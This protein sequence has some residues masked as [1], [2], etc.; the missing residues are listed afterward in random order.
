MIPCGN[1]TYNTDV[2]GKDQNLKCW[3]FPLSSMKLLF[4]VCTIS[5]VPSV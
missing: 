2:V 3:S 1:G 4:D 5:L